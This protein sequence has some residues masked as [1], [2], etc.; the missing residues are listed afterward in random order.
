MV[1]SP[2]TLDAQPAPHRRRAVAFQPTRV[3][4]RED[5]R[6][7]KHGSLMRPAGDEQVPETGGDRPRV[8]MG[9]RGVAMLGKPAVP[10]TEPLG[11]EERLGGEGATLADGQRDVANDVGE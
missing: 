8:L 6:R 4:I 10:S 11:G 1:S 3:M 5:D 9:R 2:W 7:A